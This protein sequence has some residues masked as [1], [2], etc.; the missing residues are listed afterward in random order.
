MTIDKIYINT[1][2]LVKP[3]LCIIIN[4]KLDLK[5]DLVFTFINC[6]YYLVICSP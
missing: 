6:E 5:T 3:S 1:I 2:G 4:W